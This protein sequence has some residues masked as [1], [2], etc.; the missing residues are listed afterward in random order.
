MLAAPRSA[1][2]ITSLEQSVVVVGRLSRCAR[3]KSPC[4]PPALQV[5]G[6]DSG[7]ASAVVTQRCMCRVRR[8]APTASISYGRT[9]VVLPPVQSKVPRDMAEA[10]K[11]ALLSAS[12]PHLAHGVTA[13]CSQTAIPVTQAD[14][15][16]ALQRPRAGRAEPLAANPFARGPA[17]GAE[18]LL[19][20]RPRAL[21]IQKHAHSLRTCAGEPVGGRSRRTPTRAPFDYTAPGGSG[22]CAHAQ[23][24]RGGPSRCGSGEPC[25]VEQPTGVPARPGRS[26]PQRVPAR[27]TSPS[28]PSPQPCTAPSSFASRTRGQQ[29]PDLRRIPP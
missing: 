22:V 14:M 8:R 18:A 3:P 4:R 10:V 24:A 17:M 9:R 26:L 21:R 29:R 12:C 5:A 23:P 11:R 2:A 28:I 20:L 25:P 19:P 6:V 27:H 7:R 16:D 15:G 13:G 1:G